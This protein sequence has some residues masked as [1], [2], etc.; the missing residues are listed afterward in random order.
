MSAERTNDW[1]LGS[2]T[3]HTAAIIPR[4]IPI[5]PNGTLRLIRHK[6]RIGALGGH[7]TKEES[8]RFGPET[9]LLDLGAMTPTLDRE[10]FEEGRVALGRYLE[11]SA[12]IL[13]IAEILMVRRDTNTSVDT[14]TP[15]II[16]QIPGGLPFTEQVIRVPWGHI[17]RDTYPDAALAL[18]HLYTGKRNRRTGPIMPEFLNKWGKV[19]Y[20]LSPNRRYLKGEPPLRQLGFVFDRPTIPERYPHDI[21]DWLR[22]QYDRL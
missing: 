7:I 13:G 22:D 21:Q 9:N 6:G 1:F 10:T 14:I 16:C 20:E 18:I 19:V 2:D 11:T 3:R 4:V 15:M 8:L 5:E 12:A 17:P